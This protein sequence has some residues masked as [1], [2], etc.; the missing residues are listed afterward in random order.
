M[1]AG[2]SQKETSALFCIL[3]EERYENICDERYKITAGAGESVLHPIL[4]VQRLSVS[5][6]RP[7]LLD[8]FRN[9]PANGSRTN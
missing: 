7:V 8:R 6:P 5:A 4:T 9:L 3:E 1:S 2:V